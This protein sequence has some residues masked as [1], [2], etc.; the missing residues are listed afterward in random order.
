MNTFTKL[1]TAAA[2]AAISAISYAVEQEWL[3]DFEIAKKV[4]AEQKKDILIDFT[5][6][7]WCGWCI[8]LDKEVFKTPYFNENIGKNYVLLK[9]D[10]PKN[11]EAITAEQREKNN[12]LAKQFKISG[13]P[14]ICLVDCE[15]KLYALTGYQ[16]GGPEA[17]LKHLNTLQ[18][19]K[20]KIAKYKE[21]RAKAET[22]TG[23]EKAKMLHE[24]GGWYPDD[25]PMPENIPEMIVQADPEN[26]TKLLN[27]YL[28]PTVIFPAIDLANSEL[29]TQCAP[30]IGFI[31]AN[32]RKDDPKIKAEVVERQK[33]VSYFLYAN[34]C[35]K[36]EELNKKYVFEGRSKQT[37]LLFQAF[38]LWAEDQVNKNNANKETLLKLIDEAIAIEPQSP[39]SKRFNNL[40]EE[41]M[42]TK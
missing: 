3:T 33:R 7:D 10:F 21:L 23:P 18:G 19:N 27:I 25:M 16:Q 17:Y 15:G 4:A 41:I 14:T 42:Q 36:L 6:S 34:I 1:L 2:F 31:R 22:L 29:M 20:E 30:D 12:Q 40:R 11:K 9:V 28:I 26:K 13:Y 37:Q 32:A 39:E 24:A 38:K 35:S 5:G 8:R